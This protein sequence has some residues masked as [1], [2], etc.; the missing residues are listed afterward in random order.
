MK[1]L[2]KKEMSLTASPLTYFFIAF[3]L[4]SF[5]PGYPILVGSFFVCMGIF[6]TFQ[7]AREYNDTLYTALLPVRK[8]DVVKAKYLFCIGIQIISFIINS[9]ITS[10][11]L[12]AFKDVTVY[13][14]NPLMNANFA[15]LGYV[16]IVFALFNY[17]FLTGFF[18][19]AYYIGKPFIIY[20][21]VSFIVVAIGEILH[22]LPGLALLNSTTSDGFPIQMIVFIIGILIYILG[23]YLSFN[24]SKRIFNSIDL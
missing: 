16:L 15:Y 20:C 1:E 11:R 5:I 21:I 22:H 6:Y 2:L 12:T 23:T 19:T 13:V 7:F 24:K 17:I 9:I 10:I 18:K 3:S 14:E 8:S 4:M